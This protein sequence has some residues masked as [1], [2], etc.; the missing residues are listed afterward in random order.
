MLEKDK[1]SICKIV[2]KIY[3]KEILTFN[4]KLEHLNE[5]NNAYIKINSLLESFNA[6]YVDIHLYLDD[7]FYEWYNT[8]YDKVVDNF[9]NEKI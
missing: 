7:L 2:R 9:L 4:N 8:G 1:V 5:Y 3:D 6:T